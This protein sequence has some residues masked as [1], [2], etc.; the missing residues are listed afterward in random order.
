MQAIRCAHSLHSLCYAHFSCSEDLLDAIQDDD[1]S[2]D[3]REALQRARQDF[4]DRVLSW[5]ESFNTHLQPPLEDAARGAMAADPA[6][7]PAPPTP[8]SLDGSAAGM[9]LRPIVSYFFSNTSAPTGAS[10]ANFFSPLHDNSDLRPDVKNTSA[11][12]DIGL[13]PLRDPDCKS[14]IWREVYAVNIPLPSSFDC[15]VLAQSAAKSLVDW[16]V[17]I[18][19]AE[20]RDALEAL[21]SHIIVSESLKVKQFDLSGKVA[22]TRMGKKIRRKYDQIVA[23]ADDYRRA[24]ISM[25]R[26]GVSQ[27]DPAFRLLRKKD[28][29][30]FT[31]TNSANSIGQSRKSVSW[32]WDD[33]SFV[34]NETD[35]AYKAYFAEGESCIFCVHACYDARATVKRVHWF[36]SS[37]LCARWNEEIR[38]LIEEMRRTIRFFAHFRRHWTTIADGYE[39]EGE[40]G[41]AAH[42]RK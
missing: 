13:P 28:V 2:D 4:V 37:A 22:H 35:P 32:I 25:L 29:V 9:N 36:R 41:P 38:L 34:G 30:Q 16:E 3:V 14:D 6:G 21:R 26:L 15:R 40:S 8:P 39:L 19:K 10:Q 42:A 24:R 12:A 11:R 27:E 31:L 7:K 23:N 20:A 17:I 5:Q 1:G 33:F 18:R